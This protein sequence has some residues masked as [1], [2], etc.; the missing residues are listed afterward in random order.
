MNEIFSPDP[1]FINENSQSIFLVIYTMLGTEDYRQIRIKKW[2]EEIKEKDNA[3]PEEKKLLFLFETIKKA[4]V[5]KEKG[6][7]KTNSPD[8]FIYFDWNGDEIEEWEWVFKQGY[9][10]KHVELDLVKEVRIS[11]IWK[12]LCLKEEKENFSYNYETALFKCSTDS[13]FQWE[14]E[15]IHK[16]YHSTYKEA[17]D[18]HREIWDGLMDEWRKSQGI[19]IVRNAKRKSVYE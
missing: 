19:F 3:L 15:E 16:E 1:L 9:F 10:P 13:T 12:G 4:C 18:A 17:Q 11:T 5:E 7:E 8:K 6:R 14:W 2:Y